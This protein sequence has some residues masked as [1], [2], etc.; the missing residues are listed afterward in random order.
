MPHTGPEEIQ[1]ELTPELIEWAYRQGIFPMGTADGGVEWYSPDPR[2][3]IE[4]DF[5][6]IPSRLR[7]TCRQGKFTVVIDRNFEKIIRN[8]SGRNET[9]IT[10]EIV[11]CYV[12]LHRLGKAHSVEAYRDDQLAGGLYGVALGGAFM[13]ESMFTFQ[14]DASKV[15][16]VYL[17]DRLKSKGFRLLDTQFLTSHLKTFGATEISREAYLR[18]LEK[19]LL[20]NCSFAN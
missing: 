2:G 1:P 20:L 15:C 13:G 17:V 7:R 11:R 19:A 8:C 10:E 3:V 12:A 14:K 6:H 16:L 4:L 9:W 18:K 5:F